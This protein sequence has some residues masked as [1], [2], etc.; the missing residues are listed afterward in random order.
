MKNKPF[1]VVD[2]ELTEDKEIIQ[3]S[4]T[5]LS[6]DFKKISSIDYYVKPKKEI[7]IFVSEFTGITP[8][9]LEDKPLFKEIAYGIYEYIKDCTLVCHGLQSDY[10]VLK[11]N[12]MKVGIKYIPYRTVDTVE[13][14]RILFPTQKS[15]R[16]V[17][18][19]NS[20]NLY[21]GT[22]YHNALIDVEVT[23]KLLKKIAEKI[24]YIDESNYLKVKE[25][26][27]RK[28]MGYFEFFNL[29]RKD[30][31]E[32]SEDNYI[33]FDGIKFKKINDSNRKP[34]EKGNIL[35]SCIDEYDYISIHG[36]KNYEVLKPKNEYM[37][38]NI[39]SMFPKHRN[40]NLDNLL[41]KLY[42]WILETESGD[43]SELNL[44][45]SEQMLLEEI[46]TSIDSSLES[47]YFEKKFN[48]SKS[49]ENIVTNHKNIEFLLNKDYFK[50][51][52]L[53]FDDKKILGRE[54]NILNVEYYHYRQVITEL[55]IAISQNP[56]L[57]YLKEIQNNLNSLVKFLHEMY[58]SESLYLY[59]DSLD[60]IL[61]DIDEIIKEVRKSS[62][63]IPITKLFI[64]KLKYTLKNEKNSY[65]FEIIDQENSLFLK[66]INE[67]N[68]KNIINI[69]QFR[70]TNYLKKNNKLSIYYLD[71]LDKINTGKTLGKVLYVFKSD[72]YRDLFFSKREKK[73]NIKYVNFTSTDSFSEL[74]TDINKNIKPG[75]ICFATKD[76]LYY[77]Y[78]LNKVFDNIIV[79]NN[80]EL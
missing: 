10:L 54:L 5:K 3:F 49:K 45:S 23:V 12:F 37:P 68:V 13:L 43:L 59:Y 56:A 19:S 79:L 53:I 1:C 63:K 25:I 35:F 38:L 15:Y 9:M 16:L 8:E 6:I 24:Q 71:N 27:K 44:L 67:K 77:K 31:F 36:I 74:F 42:V 46:K 21:S 69:I 76:I 80:A 47:Y 73:S 40:S 64:K 61:E 60:F 51:Y 65:K 7:S 55:N 2:I 11:K 57:K 62:K 52:K 33:I 50:K 58:I 18:L 75:Y 70:D 66:V 41:I 14:A 78:Y 48:A 72:K 28:E 34:M 29:C 4:A 32:D 20:L 39:F 26:L 22:G 30:K 17:D